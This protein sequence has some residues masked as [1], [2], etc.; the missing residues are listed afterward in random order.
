MLRAVVP[1]RVVVPLPVVLRAVVPLV[2]VPR[3]AAPLVQEQPVSPAEE[4]RA[5]PHRVQF[6]SVMAAPVV[7]LRVVPQAVQRVA[8]IR[9]AAEF[10]A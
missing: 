1:L 2:L 3:V 7:L 10:Q 6:P 4:L 8:V 9:A 5:V